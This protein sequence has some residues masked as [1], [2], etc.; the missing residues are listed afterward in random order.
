MGWGSAPVGTT[1]DSLASLDL[2]AGPAA[3]SATNGPG[4]GGNFDSELNTTI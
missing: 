4:T 1:H 3:R 2:P